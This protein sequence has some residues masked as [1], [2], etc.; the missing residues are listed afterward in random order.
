MRNY[1]AAG[2]FLVATFLAV[3]LLAKTPYLNTPEL[4]SYDFMMST[5]R[6][7]L[8]RPQDIVIV[9]IDESS[10]QEFSDRFHWP[11]PRSVH[12]ELIR[13]LNE[14]GAR[15][16]AFDVVFDQA[17]DPDEDRALGDSIRASRAPVVLAGTEQEVKDPRFALVQ[18]I[19]PIDTLV[20]AGAKVGFVK[21]D[22]DPDGFL[23]H[24]RL[25][26]DGEPTLVT[27]VLQHTGRPVDL[28]AMPLVSSH[29]EDPQILINFVGPARSVPTVSYYQALEYQ[30]TLPKGIF[31]KKL[32]LVG[33][34]VT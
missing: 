27:Q 30:T 32:V 19:R 17:S 1:V 13:L 22:V 12:A 20:Q 7:P 26:L 8:D 23:R 31:A 2:L 6:G 16:I 28:T 14:A 33:R 18:K 11:W 9:A 15:A 10:I 4:K 5:L 25:S 21:T 29:E 3:G 24:A 34:S